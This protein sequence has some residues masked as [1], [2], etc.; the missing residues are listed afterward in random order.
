N[1]LRGTIGF[2]ELMTAVLVGSILAATASHYLVE[3]PLV[4]AV[5]R[6]AA[7]KDGA[8]RTAATAQDAYT[9]AGPR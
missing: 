3:R 4:K 9:V 7:R 2:P 1:Q 5:G 8:T 6:W